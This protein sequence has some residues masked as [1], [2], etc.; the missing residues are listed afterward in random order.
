MMM[1][2]TNCDGH[3]RVVIVTVVLVAVRVPAHPVLTGVV[4]Q[5]QVG[6]LH[7][8]HSRVLFLRQLHQRLAQP[9]ASHKNTKKKYKLSLL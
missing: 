8:W 6:G 5:E 9:L 1:A 2:G 3:N 4:E 7:V